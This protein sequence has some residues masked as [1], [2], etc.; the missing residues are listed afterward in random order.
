VV[1][2]ASFCAG[3]IANLVNVSKLLKRVFHAGTKEMFLVTCR[4]KTFCARRNVR[5]TM[6]LADIP[7][8]S[9]VMRA[10]TR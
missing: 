10:V 2:I 9:Y 5:R 4:Q 1:T 6:K 3:K 7:A 8:S